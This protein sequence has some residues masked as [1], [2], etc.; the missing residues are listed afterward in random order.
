MWTS[1]P[2]SRSRSKV[3]AQRISA[4]SG[5][6]INA[7]ATLRGKGL[8]IRMSVDAVESTLIG[9]A[10]DCFLKVSMIDYFVYGINKPSPIWHFCLRE[11]HEPL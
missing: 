4:S 8:F 9:V 7:K 10:P 2:M 6:A 1:Q 11:L 5:C 3:P